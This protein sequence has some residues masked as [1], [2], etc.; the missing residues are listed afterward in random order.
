MFACSRARATLGWRTRDAPA[1]GVA[2]NQCVPR[3]LQF[4]VPPPGSA[5]A[6]RPSHRPAPPPACPKIDDTDDL[7]PIATATLRPQTTPDSHRV[8]SGIRVSSPCCCRP[9]SLPRQPLPNPRRHR[10]HAGRRSLAQDAL[11]VGPPSPP[12]QAPTLMT[13]GQG[14]CVVHWRSRS[15]LLRVSN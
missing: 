12:L 1:T 3:G 6:T 13:A 15:G 11:R 14:R 10:Q 8:T 2:A 9:S 5:L 7:K 4:Q